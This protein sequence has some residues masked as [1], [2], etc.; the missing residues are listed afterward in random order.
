MALRVVSRLQYLTEGMAQMR[1]QD[2]DATHLVK[3]IKGRELSPNS[4][5]NVFIGGRGVAIRDSNKDRALE[6]LAEWAAPIVDAHG[7]D[8]K[9]LI[10][11][12][13]ARLSQR[14]RMISGLP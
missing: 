14:L 12:L 7:P 10:P 5:S 8:P 9:V 6:W 2:Y 11:F 3:A 4:Y 13:R 1:Q